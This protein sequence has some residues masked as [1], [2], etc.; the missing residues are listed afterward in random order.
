MKLRDHAGPVAG[1]IGRASTN[2]CARA[3]KLDRKLVCT[4]IVGV[5]AGANAGAARAAQWTL[6]NGW[7]V[8]FDSTVSF[9]VAVR[10]SKTNCSFVGND[11][12]GCVGDA[13]TPL[14]QSNPAVFSSSQDVL[15]V[16]QDDGNLNYKRWQ[17]VSANAQ[18]TSDLYVKASDGWSGLL[19]G[20]VNYDFAVDHTRRSDLDPSARNFATSNPRLLDAYVTKEFEVGDQQARVRVGNQVLSWGENLYIPGGVNSINP[21]YLPSAHQPGTPLKNL[22]IPSPMVSASSSLGPDLGIEAFYQWKWNSF[23]FDAPGTFFSTSDFVGSGGRGLYIPTSTLNAAVGAA[24]LPP[25]PRATIGDN[26]TRIVGINPA[27]GLPYNR[28]LS[29]GELA[30]PGANPVGPLLG[31]GTFVPRGPDNK[32]TNAGQGGL[33]L[34]YKFP[35]SGNE[36]GFYYQ[37]YSDKV[38][39]VSYQVGTTTA[40]PFGWQASLDYGKNRD[41]FGLSYN[42]QAGEWVIGTELSYRPRDGVAID[43]T[44]VIDP[45]NPYYCNALADFTVK[46][47]GS[48][49]KGWV[50]TQHYQLHLTGIHIMSP[51]GS[52]GW[53]LRALGASEG[54][55]TA[56]GA[57]AYYPKLK[58]NAGIP[59]AVTADY[60]LPTKLSA[61]MVLAA[62]VTYPNIFGTRASLSPDIA[63]M[64]GIGGYSATALPGFIQGAGAAVIGATI[65]FKTKPETRLRLDYTHN[66]GGSGSN[67][68]RDRDF[69]SLSMTTAF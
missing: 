28:R 37:H 40:N 58:L 22:F 13:P 47:V 6:D 8:A 38:P 31:A 52:F 4:A 39:F 21:I 24:G 59:Y 55:L 54:T 5:L 34:R 15:R 64:Q 46:P 9:G 44:T 2:A 1:A 41:L 33:A 42:F 16:N 68:L 63:V 17:P 61:G 56:E 19:R 25:F 11:N 57:L 7:Q 49:C 23:V 50:D 32:P 43:P 26:G 51:S 62:S 48:S 12:G 20:V 67:L 3:R 53:L 65:D 27:T 18:W 66:W 69:F 14:Q 30:D 36:L 60:K 10:T 45:G 29:A 35:D